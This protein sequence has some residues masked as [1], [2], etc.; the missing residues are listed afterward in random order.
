M[1]CAQEILTASHSS[2]FEA[3][4][5]KLDFE[6]AF[7]FVNRDFFWGYYWQEDLD[8]VGLIRSKIACSSELIRSLLIGGWAT[9][10]N[11]ARILGKETHFFPTSSFL[12][13]Y[14]NSL[15]SRQ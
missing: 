1:A 4:F 7:D 9:T 13:P 3:V 8:N 2:N 14:K 10:S 11:T 5:R 12:L 6:K 15:P